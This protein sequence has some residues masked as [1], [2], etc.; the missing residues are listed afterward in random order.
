MILQILNYSNGNANTH[1]TAEFRVKQTKPTG[2]KQDGRA[3]RCGGSRGT[4]PGCLWSPL[5][6]SG[7]VTCPEERGQ[8]GLVP[9]RLCRADPRGRVGVGVGV[10]AVLPV[11]CPPSRHRAWGWC[12]RW[13]GDLGALLTV[14]SR[15]SSSTRCP[16]GARVSLLHIG[17]D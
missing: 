14:H 6:V 15:T 16:C 1:K 9:S 5:Q 8:R 3:G 7:C 4:V 11:R 2:V 13:F 17:V 10:V 12:G